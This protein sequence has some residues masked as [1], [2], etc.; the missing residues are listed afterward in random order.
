[1]L[2]T[3][4]KKAT[5][6]CRTVITAVSLVVIF[7]TGT[8]LLSSADAA[9]VKVALVP[10][11]PHPFFAPWEQAAADAKKDFNL[12]DGEYKVP[13][14]W[15]LD[16]QNKLL[17]SLAAQ[18]FNAFGIFPGDATGTNAMMQELLDFG[19]PSVAIGGCTQS[20]SPAQFCLA[21]DV[22]R[23]VYIGTKQ[24]IKEMGG[25]GS[26]L[27]VCSRLVDPNTVLRIAAIDKAIEE[28][29]PDIKLYQ[30]LPDT[31]SQETGDQKINGLLAAKA[32]EIDGI[33]STGYVSSVVAARSLRNMGD[34][35]IKMIGIDDDPIVLQAIKDGYLQGT[36]AQNPYGQGYIASYVLKR[37]HEGCE[38]KEGAPFQETTQN[39]TF[40]DSGT[41][42][43][44]AGNIDT[45][46][47][48]LKKIAKD[49]IGSFEAKYMTCK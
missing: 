26:I 44:H 29:G 34:K 36:M 47:D 4:R 39:K 33:I 16:L 35:R 10:G 25:K 7:G 2:R 27:H 9:D 17:E 43:I 13:Q 11:G 23:S 5:M 6:I 18:G 45:Y 40:I 48:E 42:L 14:E 22:Y 21:T 28:A 12:A 15:K 37:M 32:A 31:D 38:I 8:M 30:H 46:K 20:P 3:S 41:L 1:M 19:A 49:I 24:L